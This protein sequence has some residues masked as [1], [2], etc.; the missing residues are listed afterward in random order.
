MIIYEHFPYNLPGENRTMETVYLNRD[1]YINIYLDLFFFNEFLSI[2]NRNTY[3][4]NLIIDSLR[5]I[6]F[7]NFLII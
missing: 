5:N 4:R 1:I 2:T 3:F 7:F 6:I